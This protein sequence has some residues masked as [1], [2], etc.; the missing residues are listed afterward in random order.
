M[1]KYWIYIFLIVLP[2]IGAYFSIFIFGLLGLAFYALYFYPFSFL[3]DPYYRYLKDVGLYMPNH[4]GILLIAVV[5]S[6]LYWLGYL[7]IRK[8]VL[9]GKKTTNHRP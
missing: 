4:S 5:Y 3:G 7:V 2:S 1:K 8:T 6:L 9:K